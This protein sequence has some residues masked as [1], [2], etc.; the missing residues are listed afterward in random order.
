M[1]QFVNNLS[2]QNNWHKLCNFKHPKCNIF[3]VYCSN[4]VTCTLL[5]I[6]NIHS[7][8]HT[9]QSQLFCTELLLFS[10]PKVQSSLVAQSDNNLLLNR[11][12]LNIASIH[13]WGPKFTKLHVLSKRLQYFNIEEYLTSSQHNH[14][15]ICLSFV[16]SL[17]I[18]PN[19][20][21]ILYFYLVHRL[22]IRRINVF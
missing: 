6:L 20:R 1:C 21:G 4:K 7:F 8:V 12:S 3:L 17:L 10:F 16:F 14:D 18:T 15:V 22:K 2:C 13:Q 19:R 9:I 11:K 5:K